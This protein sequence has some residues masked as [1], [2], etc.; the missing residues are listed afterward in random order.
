MPGCRPLLACIASATLEAHATTELRNDE[1]PHDSRA[2]VDEWRRPLPLTLE[3]IPP[4][5]RRPSPPPPPPPLPPPPLQLL[6]RRFPPPGVPS[7]LLHAAVD[8]R[9]RPPPGAGDEAEPFWPELWPS[10]L[11]GSRWP[12]VWPTPLCWT[13][14][15]CD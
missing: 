11:L 15:P 3:R 8:P 1:T 4:M 5:L 6:Q 7:G 2:C 12:W 14:K 9:V 13:L 10:G